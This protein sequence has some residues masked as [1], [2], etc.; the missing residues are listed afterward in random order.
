VA[1]FLRLGLDEGVAEFLAGLETR[2]TL[3]RDCDGVASPW[4]TALAFL[5]FPND[6]ATKSTKIY[7]LIFVERLG[8]GMESKSTD[9]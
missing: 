9:R 3:G 8:N 6:E 7:A 2:I 4:I 1:V 5:L